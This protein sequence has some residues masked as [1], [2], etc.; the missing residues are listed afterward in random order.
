DEKLVV[1]FDLAGRYVYERRTADGLRER[2][3]CDGRTLWHLYPEI[4]VGAK[5]PVSRFHRSWLASLV[6][7]LAPLAEDLMRGAD[8]RWVGE[9]TIAI[10][11][12]GWQHLRSTPSRAVQF[13]E[14]QLVFAEDGRLAERRRVVVPTGQVLS[15]VTYSADGSIAWF[16]GKDK[17]LA[18]AKLPVTKADAPDLT[19]DVDRLVVVPMPLRTAESLLLPPSPD[20]V[21]NNNPFGD[22]VAPANPASGWD[23]DTAIALIAAYCVSGRFHEARRIVGQR[24]YNDEVDDS[25]LGFNTLLLAGGQSNNSARPNRQRVEFQPEDGTVESDLNDYLVALVGGKPGAPDNRVPRRDNPFFDVPDTPI[26]T[27]PGR[28]DF[29][30]QLAQFRNLTIDLAKAKADKDDKRR[31][32]TVGRAIEFARDAHSTRFAWAVVSQLD[33]LVDDSQQHAALAAAYERF[34]NVGPL[35]G[36][37][38]HQRALH[39]LASGDAHAARGHFDRWYAAHLAFGIVPG[40][41]KEFYQAHQQDGALKEWRKLVDA[42]AKLLR[43][44]SHPASVVQLAAQCRAAG[45]G[46][47]ADRLVIYVLAG[48]SERDRLMTTLAAVRYYTA[49]DDDTTAAKL[50]DGLLEDEQMARWPSLWR[51]AATMADRLKKPAQALTFSER[52]LELTYKPADEKIELED[53]RRDYDMLMNRYLAAAQHLAKA[54]QHPSRR[55]VDR[56]VRAADRWRSLEVDVTAPCQRASQVLRLLGES[57]LAWQYL[58]TPLAMRPNEAQPWND[59]AGALK[60]EGDVDLADLAYTEAFNAEETNAQILWDHAEMLAAA[61]RKS[62]ARELY[63]Q[64]AESKWG[65]AFQSV[66]SRAKAKVK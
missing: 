7:W 36:E 13:V 25:R 30:R 20:P 42:V 1:R 66:Q 60:T 65:R 53:L 26:E 24:F 49:G 16:G 33:G 58:T 51:L 23:D 14:T 21:V 39:S 47:L 52:A 29:V 63:E 54:K 4:G 43:A 2:V 10:V 6:P 19:P 17:Q 15:R 44:A 11:P 9:R 12:H 31:R 40:L 3:I 37:A 56:L 46:P 48:V 45:D 32:E 35:A 8:V 27:S 5:R 61:G 38:V 18:S 28:N 50:V 62:Q 55:L 57:D 64:I 59:M 41:S 22:G 34:E